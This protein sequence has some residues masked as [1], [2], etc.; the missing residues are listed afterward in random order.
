M[1]VIQLLKDILSIYCP[2]GVLNRAIKDFK[3]FKASRI[4]TEELQY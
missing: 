1:F 2:P 3:A 4:N